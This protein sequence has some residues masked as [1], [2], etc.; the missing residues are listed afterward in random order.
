M[1]HV[2]IHVGH[3]FR[4]HWFL[5]FLQSLCTHNLHYIV[6]F[7]S[8]NHSLPF[9]K[10]SVVL[11]RKSMSA[12][13]VSTKNN[14]FTVNV[15]SS[16]LSVSGREPDP[17]P[18]PPPPPSTLLYRQAAV[19]WLLPSE[20]LVTLR[21]MSSNRDSRKRGGRGERSCEVWWRQSAEW[22]WSE[23]WTFG[24]LVGDWCKQFRTMTGLC[25]HIKNTK[26]CFRIRFSLTYILEMSNSSFSALKKDCLV[27]SGLNRL[28]C[29][30]SPGGEFIHKK[31]E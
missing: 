13:G 7:A 15:L 6:L 3:D 8:N 2:G 9:F 31:K 16:G 5:W 17:P 25:T 10:K 21:Q 28:V 14:L 27:C 18:P 1:L 29:L 20:S 12:C 22:R 19:A 30:F 24:R 4:R 23:I 26:L 11:Q